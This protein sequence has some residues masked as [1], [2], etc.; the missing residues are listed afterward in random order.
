MAGA[1]V[2]DAAAAAG[3]S[4][5]SAGVD[6]VS[7]RSQ[8]HA[9]CRAPPALFCELRDARSDMVGRAGAL[10]CVLYVCACVRACVRVSVC[11]SQALDMLEKILR[12]NP[13]ERIS[14]EQVMT[15]A[16]GPARPPPAAPR[17]RPPPPP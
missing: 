16:T 6:T 9:R 3:V 17:P 15:A 4:G 2:A 12:F 5:G 7:C 13:K 14:A 8:A 10:V 1:A 11:V